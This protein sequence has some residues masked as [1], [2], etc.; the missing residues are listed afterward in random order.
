MEAVTSASFLIINSG[1]SSI[2]FAIYGIGESEKLKTSGKL[3]G[4]LLKGISSS[5]ETLFEEKVTLEDRDAATGRLI[6]LLQSGGHLEGLAGTGYRIV[7]GGPWY[8]EP[9]V[10]DAEVLEKLRRLVDFA[11]DHIPDQIAAIERIGKLLPKTPSV[12]CFDT[13]FH[14][15]MPRRA[16]LYGLTRELADEGLV[17]YGFH[18]LSYSYIVHEM[19]SRKILPERLIVAHLG[20]GGSL[21]AIRNGESIDTSMGFTPTAGF[22]MSS[23]SGD[24]DPGIILYLLR[25]RGM[26]H[27]EVSELVNKKG[28][29]LGL[30]GISSDMQ[31]LQKEALKNKNAAEAIEVFVYQIRKFV[32]AYCAALGG[33]DELV[34]TGG[35]GENSAFVRA[36]VCE[37]LGYLGIALEPEKNRRGADVISADGAGPV[38]RVMKTNEELMIV[39]SMSAILR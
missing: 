35:I 12:A 3:D 13:A 14:R 17:R 28:G 7:H 4:S 15:T 38:V 2:K 29:L 19:R 8:R 32:G 22:L 24:L 23:R 33:L 5:G 10:V 36:A 27:D 18:G 34:F 26:N 9:V 1:S 6:G 16:Q 25:E 31:Q 30:S 37:G 21:A 39:R 20:N 11:P